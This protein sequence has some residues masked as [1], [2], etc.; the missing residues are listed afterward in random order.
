MASRRRLLAVIRSDFERIHSSFKFKPKELVPVPGHPDIALPYQDLL[1][2]EAESADFEFPQV[3]NGQWS[4]LNIRDLLNGVD[5]EG[6][7]Q[8]RSK[9]RP[10]QR[11]PAPVLQLLPQRRTPAG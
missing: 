8:A 5:L 7:R 1:V 11:C 6:S 2:M 10:L 3:I 4:K 9:L